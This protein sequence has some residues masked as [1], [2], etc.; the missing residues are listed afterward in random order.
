MNSHLAPEA[1]DNCSATAAA[2][3]IHGLVANPAAWLLR[4]L[5]AS[6]RACF[7]EIIQRFLN[8]HF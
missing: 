7:V 2:L 5:G 8:A 6:G 3:P 4:S 1:T